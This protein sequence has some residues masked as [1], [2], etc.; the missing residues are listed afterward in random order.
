MK[1]IRY[2]L[3]WLLDTLKGS[4]V[5]SHYNEIKSIFHTPY[6]ESSIK[7]KDQ[8][9]SELLQYALETTSFYK[10]LQI[11]DKNIELCNFPVI[12]KSIIKDDFDSFLSD[13]YVDKKEILRKM[14]TSGS[15]GTPFFV[16]QDKKK[17]LRSKADLIFFYEL[18]NYFVGD[19][20]YFLRIWNQLNKKSK[21]DCW[22]ENYVMSDTTNLSEDNILRFALSL[23]ADKQEKV[24]IAY[25]SSLETIT[26]HRNSFKGKDLRVKSIIPGAE[27]LS[28]QAKNELKEM[29][30]CPVFM[31]YSNQENG[32][33]AQQIDDSDDYYINEAS[34]KIEFLKLE[35]D[36]DADENEL[37]RVV[38]TD[39]FNFA[40]PIIRYDTGDL[41]KYCYLKD[42]KGNK[43][44]I[45]KSIEGRKV[46]FIYNTSGDLL[47]PHI[48]TNTMWKYS[49]Y[50]N[51]FQF[52]QDTEFGYIVKINNN[53]AFDDNELRLD[54]I[55]FLGDKANISIEYVN[56]IP[57]LASGKRKK[58][59]NNWKS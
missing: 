22:K 44:K 17:V 2:S 14:S 9:L 46:D 10:K 33:L 40:M 16:Y 31:R 13:E 52:I 4:P 1:N 19:R 28:I 41:A 53:S 34:Y 23:E 54:L 58:I 51:Q 32:I 59:V 12:N 11:N 48:I 42:T 3:F 7:K 43:K 56:E 39:L 45:I 6:S 37:A 21:L 49:K 5:K 57:Q 55:Q 27:A 30:N 36:I 18:G 25:S 24:L 20:L 35:E 38:I 50:I 15:T 29:F 47:S 8:R 26:H